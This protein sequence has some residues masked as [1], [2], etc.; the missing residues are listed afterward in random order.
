MITWNSGWT[1]DAL[2]TCVIARLLWGPCRPTGGP[3][4]ANCRFIISP[5]EAILQQE[6]DIKE[7]KHQVV[8]ENRKWWRIECSR[9]SKEY[10]HIGMIKWSIQCQRA[11]QACV[12]VYLSA[13]GSGIC[14]SA[15][16]MGVCV[17]QARNI[18][19]ACAFVC[20]Q[21]R[22]NIPVFLPVP[23]ILHTWS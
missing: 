1:S 18:Y 21:M 23:C 19:V 12:L 15:M 9:G 14:S 20:V 13:D 11:T 8:M 17:W 22:H 4:G 7:E 6:Q 16:S 3:P 5:Y 2:A 10:K